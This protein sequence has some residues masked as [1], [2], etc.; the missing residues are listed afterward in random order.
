MGMFFGFDLQLICNKRVTFLNFTFT[1]NNVYD[2]MLSENKKF[3][4]RLSE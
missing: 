2:H 4:E 1:V 3:V